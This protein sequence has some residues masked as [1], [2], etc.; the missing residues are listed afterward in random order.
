[1][2]AKICWESVR[3]MRSGLQLL[4]EQ[5]GPVIIQLQQAA[6]VK[7]N[8]RARHGLAETSGVG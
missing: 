5:L 2:M 3:R 8:Q 7:R 1:M 4:I 6:V